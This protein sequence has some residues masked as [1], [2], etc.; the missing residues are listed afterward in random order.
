MRMVRT[1][2]SNVDF[3]RLVD[4]LDEELAE[5][6][7]AERDFYAPFNKLDKIKHVVLVFNGDEAAAC[8]SIK[9]Y[10]PG[11][12]EV[13]RMYTAPHARSKGLGSV[14]LQEL[15]R[16]SR[17]M[18]YR[19]CIL[20]TGLRQPEAIALY[21]KNGFKPIE[22]YGQY[23]GVANSVCFEFILA[24]GSAVSSAVSLNS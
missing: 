9:E 23:K 15:I 2:A 14:V 3:R 1:D 7:G 19:R 20:E 17:E 24:E 4:A 6:D 18:G 11:T 10:E 12:M 8:G 16:W 13:K 21:R 5:R 22:N